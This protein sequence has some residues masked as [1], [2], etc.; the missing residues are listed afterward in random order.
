M[1]VDRLEAWSRDEETRARLVVQID[2]TL[3]V[4]A[5]AGTGKTRALVDQIVALVLAG[6]K[7]DRLV[8]ITFTE[9]AAGELKDRVRAGLEGARTA[10]PDLAL[11]VDEALGSLDRAQISTIHAFGL[12]LLRSFAAESGIDPAFI[13]QDELLAERRQQERWR[14]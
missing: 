12:T 6:R 3:F 13:L 11:L 9:K 5:G 10:H 7:I 1:T 8:A 14:S 4:E 2:Q